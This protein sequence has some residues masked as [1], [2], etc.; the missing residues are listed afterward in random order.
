[1]EQCGNNCEVAM[2]HLLSMAADSPSRQERLFAPA[3][4]APRTR[5]V[6][7]G[8]ALVQL[9]TAASRHVCNVNTYMAN[10]AGGL[11]HALPE[12]EEGQL[13][14]RRACDTEFGRPHHRIDCHQR[15]SLSRPG[16]A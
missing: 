7:A 8:Q 13:N 11:C 6:R 3:P 12:R 4:A 10:P 2:E 9:A 1:M 14:P 5:E 15:H 16:E